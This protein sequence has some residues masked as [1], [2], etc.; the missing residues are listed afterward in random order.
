MHSEFQLLRNLCSPAVKAHHLVMKPDK[1]LR[2]EWY[3][4]MMSCEKCSRE[5]P[6]NAAFCGYCGNAVNKETSQLTD[7]VTEVEMEQESI[8]S[9]DETITAVEPVTE[10]VSAVTEIFVEEGETVSQ[11]S[12]VQEPIRSEFKEKTQYAS[13][14]HQQE[15]PLKQPIGGE[16]ARVV[17]TSTYFWMLLVMLVPGLNLIMLLIWS[18]SEKINTNRRNLARAALVWLGIGIVFAIIALIVFII[19]FMSYSAFIKAPFLHFQF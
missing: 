2:K 14:T 18:F 12:T 9:S 15:T 11:E 19:S 17:R 10:E 6:E 16:Q 8:N 5:I 3:N 7:V 4:Y 13:Y 1:T